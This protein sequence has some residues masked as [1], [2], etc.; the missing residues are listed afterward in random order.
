MPKR[1]SDTSKDVGRSSLT[2]IKLANMLKAHQ[3]ASNLKF[4]IP[5]RNERA[6]ESPE[7]FVAFS[8][9]IIRSGGALPLHT[10][11][12][13]VL[14]YFELAPLQLSPN[15]WVMLSGLYVLYHQ[16]HSRGP[17][18]SEVHYF[19][20]L[21]VNTSAPEFYQLQKV[22]AHKGN[23]LVEG[24]MPNRGS[25]KM[26]YFFTFSGPTRHTSFNTPSK[27]IL[28]LISHMRGFSFYSAFLLLFF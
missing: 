4:V 19:Y 9:A 27:T 22:V 14:N 18:M 8:D 20:T 6:S 5:K 3:L 17:S 10:F 24:S 7:G 21:R 15:S 16:V 1:T 28:T 2:S 12:V 23:S 13:K 26:D 25:W 11:F